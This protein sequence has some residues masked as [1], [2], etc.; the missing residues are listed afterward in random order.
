MSAAPN[1]ESDASGLRRALR[2]RLA[3]I[4]GPL[5][6]LAEGLLGEDDG[7]IDWLAV[8]PTGR[9]WVVLVDGVSGD[10]RLLVRGLA[11]RAWVRARLPDWRQ[12][13][14]DLP[15]SRDA[16]P[17]L[18]LLAPEFSRLV[19]VAAREVDGNGI[20]LARYWWQPGPR[21]SAE[22]RVER[23][24]PLESSPRSDALQPPV[25][26]RLFSSFKSGLTDRDFESRGG[27]SAPRHPE[28]SDNSR[29]PDDNS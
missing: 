2:S 13:A 5:Q 9:L 20:R 27:L 8:E 3:A 17:L 1:D 15:A 22:L 21:G 6:V 4:G 26:T 11:Q 24:A 29:P 19:R 18:V 23:L 28:G 10:E 12:L 25:P 14:R 7:R 16:P